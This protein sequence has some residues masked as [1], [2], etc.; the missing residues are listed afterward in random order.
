[1]VS[2]AWLLTA[3]D[4]LLS[5]VPADGAASAFY[6]TNMY[7]NFTG[8]AAVGG[9]SGF[10]MV[11]FPKVIGEWPPGVTASDAYVPK[12]RP[13][14]PNGFYGNSA[15]STGYWWNRGAC[16]YVGGVLHVTDEST[17]ALEYIP[18]RVVG[19]PHN[20]QPKEDGNAA[21]FTFVNTKSS[22]CN[23]AAEDW[24]VRSKWYNIDVRASNFQRRHLQ[25][26]VAVSPPH[27]HTNT[28]THT[29][30]HSHSP[31]PPPPPPPFTQVND[32]GDRSFNTFGLVV[33]RNVNIRCRTANGEAVNPP[34]QVTTNEKRWHKKSFK[35]FR[36]YDTGQS[37]VLDAWQI[38]DCG[39]AANPMQ[40]TDS[41]GQPTTE[42]RAVQLWSIPHGVNMPQNQ[43]IMRNITYADG[44]PDAT[45][46]ISFDVGQRDTYGAYFMN[47]FDA[48]GSLTM[49]R[50][51][52]SDC[53]PTWVGSAHTIRA[54][55]GAYQQTSANKWFKLTGLDDGTARGSA[56]SGDSRCDL[57]SDAE[58][59]MWACDRGSVSV[60][61][62]LVVPNERAQ[63]TARTKEMWGRVTHWGDAVADGPPLSGDHQVVG[64]HDHAHRGGWFLQYHSAADDE[65][66][67]SSPKKL[68][69][70][71]DQIEDGT[72][73]M[74]ALAYPAGTTFAIYRK[75]GSGQSQAVA[76]TAAASV[77]AVRQEGNTPTTYYFDGTYLYLR[78]ADPA[79]GSSPGFGEDSLYVPSGSPRWDAMQIEA[80][81]A[82]ATGCG[83][84]DWCQAATQDAP[85][86]SVGAVAGTSPTTPCRTSDGPY[87][88]LRDS[89]GLVTATPP[90]STSS[91]P[92]P[93]PPA[94]VTYE[95]EIVVAGTIEDARANEASIRAS[96]AARAGVSAEKIG[97]KFTAA[98]VVIAVTIAA[99]D[100]TELSAIAANVDPL[101]TDT[102]QAGSLLGSS[103]T[104]ESI[105]SRPPPATGANSD[106]GDG[107][108]GVI[109]GAAAGGVGVLAVGVLLWC[110]FTKR[111]K[112]QGVSPMPA[113]KA[114]EA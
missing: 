50:A 12:N 88:P 65:N 48:D 76:Y 102:T 63:T 70:Q 54:I 113:G 40:G 92:P 35:M 75:T 41:N 14:L 51:S 85:A 71:S 20:R 11:S 95:F 94:A 64:P 47:L 96:V 99:T 86:A 87:W 23:V 68:E 19:P 8:N 6:I 30:T 107:S 110:Y 89:S 49:R 29:H 37:H 27:T 36:A 112:R 79:S 1:M 111:S 91:P 103:V 5:Q 82:S 114:V 53:R 108:L 16:F 81:W 25:L 31:S 7:N 98:S 17:G 66:T 24:N 9:F 83:S 45:K 39:T 42:F 38:Q 90:Q 28:H 72:V 13:S 46:L 77:A 60:A 97:I 61:A 80:T 62:I 109:I 100:A 105:R 74:L 33:F 56:S 43:L 15:R 67:W 69:I 21:W 4:R 78:M 44:P 57:M 55:T 34:N 22:L 10:A 18:G 93:P 32:I 73:L 26:L 2:C 84:A 52:P 58:Y 104:V 101:L 59:P 106:G 3:L